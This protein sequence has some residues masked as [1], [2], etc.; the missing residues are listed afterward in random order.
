M[1]TK[2]FTTVMTQKD[3]P[4]T[5]QNFKTALRNFEEAGRTEGNAVM[6]AKEKNS[7]VDQQHL[8]QDKTK[9]DLMEHVFRVENTA[10]NLKIVE[11]FQVGAET[12]TTKVMTRSFVE[13]RRPTTYVL[14]R[15]A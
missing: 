12:A 14:K 11:N 8:F 10:T 7:A 3:A 9:P 13:K 1:N 6:N 5:F 2:T 4:M 15:T